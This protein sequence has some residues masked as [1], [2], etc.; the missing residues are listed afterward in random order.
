LDPRRQLAIVAL[1]YV[2]EGF[3]MGVFQHVLTVYF[4]RHGVALSEI[5]LLSALGYAWMVKPLWSPLVERIGTRQAWIGGSLIA[6]AG[7]LAVLA[8]MPANPLGATL[9]AALAIYCLASAT[10]DIAIDG[11]TIGL[12]DRGR[13]GP[14]NAVRTTA[15]RVGLALSGSGMLLLAGWL[16]WRATFLAASALTAG[17][18]LSLAW[19]PPIALPPPAERRPLHSL[20]AWLARPGVVSV[21]AFV[22][23]FRIGDRAMG[24]MLPTF[25]VDRGF[26]DAELALIANLL[27]AGA[28][29][30]GAIAGGA[31]V[32]RAGI[33]PALWTTGALALASNLV[34]AAAAAWPETGRIGVYVASVTEALSSGAVGAAFVSY[35]MRICEQ[36]HAAVQYAVLT[37]LYAS[38]G[39]LLASASG[40]IAEATGYAG[41]FALTAAFAAPAFAFLARA[42]RWIEPVP[43]DPPEP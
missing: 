28:T 31:L 42:A 27:G 18:A 16:G 14:A 22:V 33:V 10:Q 2:I 24:P 9:F 32:A 19:T 3:P 23:L 39:T 11:Y 6:M 17:F 12:V 30:A 36:R 37:G 43:G 35:L 40:R 13:E 15:Y 26:S 38:V 21:I 25:W 4:R 41:Y 1:V 29:I 20:R 5:G 34:Y 8:F 7:S